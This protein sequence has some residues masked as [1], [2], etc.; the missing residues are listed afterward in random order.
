MKSI[1][2]GIDPGKDGAVVAINDDGTVAASFMTRR[3]FT[4]TIGKSSKREYL[5]SRMSYAIKCLGGKHNI[6]LAV[7]E[8]QSARPGQGVSSTFSTGFGYG[9]WVGILATHGIPFVEVR[10]QTW[11]SN[12][13]RDVPGEGKNRSVYAVMNRMPDLDLTPG[14]KRKPHDGLADAACLAL[15]AYHLEV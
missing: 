6:K 3:D 8:K 2:L 1:Y 7:V 5:P 10:P 15:Y 4:T 13:L 11:T 12:I 9:L 14:L